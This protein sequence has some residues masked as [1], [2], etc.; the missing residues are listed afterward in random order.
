MTASNFVFT[1]FFPGAEVLSY[2]LSSVWLIFTPQSVESLNLLN[3]DNN[4]AATFTNCL[5]FNFS[6]LFKLDGCFIATWLFLMQT[7]RLPLLQMVCISS[8]HQHVHIIW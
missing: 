1:V 4:K 8:A 7:E 6:S 2:L 3:R 5:A